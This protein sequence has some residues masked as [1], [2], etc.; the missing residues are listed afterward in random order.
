MG[1]I[2]AAFWTKHVTLKNLSDFLTTL[3]DEIAPMR[4]LNLSLVMALAQVY[5]ESNDNLPLTHGCAQLFV[6]IQDP[7]DALRLSLLLWNRVKTNNVTDLPS[8]F[9]D[10]IPELHLLYRGS[11]I[12]RSTPRRCTTKICAHQGNAS[13]WAA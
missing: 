10:K 9:A 7:D 8:M 12:E 6:M 3:S 1:K 4:S 5:M 13:I 11:P 2:E